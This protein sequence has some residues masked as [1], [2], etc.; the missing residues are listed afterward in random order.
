M[1]AAKAVETAGKLFSQRKYQE[2]ADL[3]R[4]VV[5]NHPNLADAYN[6]LGVSLNALGDRLVVAGYSA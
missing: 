4:Q 3:A 6:V 2:A 5:K 1:P